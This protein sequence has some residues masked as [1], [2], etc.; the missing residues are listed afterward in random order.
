MATKITQ[1]EQFTQAIEVAKEANRPDLVTFFEERIAVL[2]KKSANRK[3]SK[4]QEATA[5]LRDALI[6][7]LQ[8]ADAPMT[9]A[10]IK[11]AVVGLADATSQKVT[12]LI[13]P[14]VKSDKNPDGVVERTKDKKVTYY[15]YI[16]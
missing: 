3:P 11:A 13:T 4:A 7:A 6:E 9:V 14:L 10:D 16:G 5:E 12:G 1:R 15:A 2:D 8:G